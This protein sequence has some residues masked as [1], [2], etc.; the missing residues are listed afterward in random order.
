MKKE[1]SSNFTVAEFERSRMAIRLN[2]PNQMSDKEYQNAVKLAENVLQPVR[3]Q[4]GLTVISSGFRSEM[5]NKHVGGVPSSHHVKGMAADF[6]VPDTDNKEVADWIAENLEFTQIILEFYEGGNTGF[7]HVSYDENDLR[8][9]YLKASRSKTG[10]VYYSF[11]EVDEEVKEEE[12]IE[13]EEE[14]TTPPLSYSPF[15]KR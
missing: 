14:E 8:K 13:E 15:Y 7:I 12:Q 10:R 2:I 6:E 3:E 9:E 4:F 11:M 5:L 1:L